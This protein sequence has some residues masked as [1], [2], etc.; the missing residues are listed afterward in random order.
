MSQLSRILAVEDQIL[1]LLDLVDNL[2]DYGIEAVPVT[3]ARGAVSLLDGVD[4]LITDIELPGGYNGLQLARLA[5]R[6]RPGMPIVVVSGGVTPE[7]SDLPAG[8]L[9]FPKPYRVED[10]VAALKRQAIPQAA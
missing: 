2:A 7:P 6:L 5:A 3:S 9:F 10:L 8:A 1:L 4:A